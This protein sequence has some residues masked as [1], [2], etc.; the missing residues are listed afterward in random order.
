M[1]P[2]AEDLAQGYIDG[3]A[4]WAEKCGAGKVRF[5]YARLIA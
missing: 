1:C 2:K 3:K 4:V 5:L